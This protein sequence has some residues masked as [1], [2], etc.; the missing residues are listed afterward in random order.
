MD[1]PNTNAKEVHQLVELLGSSTRG[2]NVRALLLRLAA[3]NSIRDERVPVMPI[4]RDA[5]KHRLVTD[6]GSLTDLGSSVAMACI[7]PIEVRVGPHQADGWPVHEHQ[8]GVVALCADPEP[9]ARIAVLL[10]ADNLAKLKD[11]ESIIANGH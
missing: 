8:G 5:A 4:L 2:R 9:A 3:G 7:P 11:Y 6:A 10:T 1:N